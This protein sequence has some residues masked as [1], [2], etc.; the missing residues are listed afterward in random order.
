MKRLKY[1]LK[2][3]CLARWPRMYWAARELAKGRLEPEL[4]LIEPLCPS[5]GTFLDVGAN[6]GAYSFYAIRAGRAVHAFEPQSRLAGVLQRGL[7]QQ[8]LQIH[9]T[10][11]SDGAGSSELRVPRNDIGYSTIERANRL[12][13]TADLRH[14]IETQVVETVR[15]DDL[16][17][18]PVSL[19]KIDVEGHEG[20]VLAG[21][22]ALLERDTPSLIVEVED[23]HKEGSRDAVCELLAGFGYS[24]FVYFNGRLHAQAALQSARRNL[25]FIHPKR[26]AAVSAALF[27]EVP[28]ATPAA[29]ASLN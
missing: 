16:D 10:A 27:A 22:R 19:L 9:N 18:G 21:A 11:V 2:G 8:G 4:E 5:G 20:A 13:G 3:F 24:C 23:R 12:E 7:G 17:L 1:L 25:I 15:L 28:A 14:G 6:W 29:L 26:R